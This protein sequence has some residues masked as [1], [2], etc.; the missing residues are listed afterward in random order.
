LKRYSALGGQFL[1]LAL[2]AEA[3]LAGP[4]TK[5]PKLSSAIV[6]A[7]L[8]GRLQKGSDQQPSLN[9]AF[10]LSAA[11]LQVYIEMVEVSEAALGELRKMGVTVEVSDHAQRLVQARVPPAQLEAVADLPIVRFIRLPD[12]GVHNRQG[13]A[14]RRHGT[15]SGLSA[16]GYS[17]H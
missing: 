4:P 7:L 9:P 11:G 6:D 13:S 2:F 10:R 8:S 17:R 15:I 12:Y 3:C 14:K 16:S 5:H 1:L